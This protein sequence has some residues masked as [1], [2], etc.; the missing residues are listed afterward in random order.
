MKNVWPKIPWLIL[1][2]PFVILAVSYNSLPDQI[3]IARSFFGGGAIIAPKSLFT[4]FRVPLIETVCAAAIE[5]MRRKFA[6]EVADYHRMWSIL[7]WTVALKSML[8]AFEIA[9]SATLARD[10]FYPTVGV[11]AVGIILALVRGRRFFA[12]FFSGEWKLG[13]VEKS[14]LVVLLILYL[15]L[16]IVPIFVFK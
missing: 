12:D 15:A 8:Q 13:I 5:I 11:V 4:V 6:G 14:M 9:S 7:L 1:L 16:G 3:L 2:L 10:F